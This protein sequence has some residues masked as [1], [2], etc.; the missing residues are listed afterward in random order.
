[1]PSRDRLAS[2][3]LH[4]ASLG[5]DKFSA[6]LHLVDSCTSCRAADNHFSSSGIRPR[7]L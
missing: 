2:I 4:S 7:N 6:E 1:M 5:V 3:N